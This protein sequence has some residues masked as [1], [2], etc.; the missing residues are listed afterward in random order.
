[1]NRR[2]RRR[3][4]RHHPEQPPVL[5]FGLFRC[6]DCHPDL[7]TTGGVPVVVHDDTCPLLAQLRARSARGER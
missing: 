7:G 1:M 4:D 2:Q 3:L 5:A 6:P